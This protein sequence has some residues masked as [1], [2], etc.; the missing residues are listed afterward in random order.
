L[1]HKKTET[2]LAIAANLSPLNYEELPF[3]LIEMFI[4]I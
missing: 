2:V 4:D 1:I 3:E